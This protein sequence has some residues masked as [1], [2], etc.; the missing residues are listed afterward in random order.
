MA[1]TASN[2]KIQY[3]SGQAKVEYALMTDSGDHQTYNP[4]GLL[5]SDRDGF[6]ATVR[7][8]GIV[9]GADIISPASGNDKVQTK[10]F[11]CYIAGALISVSADTDIAVT[12]ATTDTH[13]INSIIVDAAGAVTAVKGAEGTSFISTRGGNGGPPLIDPAK[14]EIG[15]VKTSSQTPAPVTAAEIFQE[16]EAGYQER[17]D[18][19]LWEINRIGNGNQADSDA[20]TNA[21]VKFNAALPATH[22]GPITKRV[23]IEYYTPTFATI[24]EAEEFK[25]AEESPSSSSK[26]IYRKAIASVSRSLNSASFKIYLDDGITDA[27]KK[28][29]G[30]NLMFRFYPDQ[31]RAAYSITQG[32]FG[33]ATAFPASENINATV[34]IAAATKTVGFDE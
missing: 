32:V 24:Q 3:E 6:Q 4:S 12:R 21:Y 16:V 18:Y 20:E 5:I 23:Y 25:P 19:P 9:T 15:Q 14:V 30:E 22:T 34:T 2:A 17:Y 1:R 7:P 28:L 26:S 8:N 29:D 27:L 10:A 11:T 33:F 31:N 13:V